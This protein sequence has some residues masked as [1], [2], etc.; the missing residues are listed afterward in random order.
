MD[1]L[2][3]IENHFIEKNVLTLQNLS[4]FLNVSVRTIQRMISPLDTIRSYD[5]NG[6]YFSLEKLARFNS[7]GI[8][9][10]N[11]IHFSKFGTL[12]NTLVAII[13]NSSQGM[14]ALQI[15]DVLGVDTR[16]FLFQYKDV[17]GIKREKVGNH[18]VYFSSEQRRFS[19]QLSNRKQGLAS[20]AQAPL[21][22]TAA[23]SV[24]VETIKHPD[25]TFEQL[26]EHL[27]K[28]GIKIKP[29]LIQ[30]FFVFYGIEKK[31]PGSR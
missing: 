13:N 18:Y 14:D 11:N 3:S 19:Q 29:E 2:Q 27:S 9:E 21:E 6:R 12:K 8:W 31:T 24:L 26:S 23:I 28:Q 7:M 20:L 22:G 10:Y 15:K 5:H 16:S 4:R 1:T 17:S 30:D 25:F